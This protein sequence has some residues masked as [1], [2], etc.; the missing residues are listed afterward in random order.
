MQMIFLVRYM[1]NKSF[2]CSLGTIVSQN[3]QDKELMY[4]TKTIT[5][6]S[7]SQKSYKYITKKNTS[8]RFNQIG[9]NF[10]SFKLYCLEFHIFIKSKIRET[11]DKN[12]LNMY[13]VL[14][15]LHFSHF[16]TS[17]YS[18]HHVTSCKLGMYIE[19]TVGILYS[20]CQSHQ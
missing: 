13:T 19:V 2:T 12:I 7:Q 16:C 15:K 8:K 3:S 14:S 17:F 10:L 9:S 4:Q 1:V 5:S 6:K 11:Y 20:L 18:K